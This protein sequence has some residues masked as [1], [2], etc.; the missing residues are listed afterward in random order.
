[1]VGVGPRQGGAPEHLPARG[2]ILQ[3]GLKCSILALSELLHAEIYH[4]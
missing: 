3:D 2:E 4:V 1:M